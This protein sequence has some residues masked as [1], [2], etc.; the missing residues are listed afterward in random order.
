VLLDEAAQATELAALVP[1]SLGARL[2]CLVG[3]PAPA[4]RGRAEAG[5]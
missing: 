3:D 5:P 1:M 4:A 2:V